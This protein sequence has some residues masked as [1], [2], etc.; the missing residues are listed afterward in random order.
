MLLKIEDYLSFG[1]LFIEKKHSL[2]KK[3]LKRKISASYFYF[4]LFYLISFAQKN[5]NVTIH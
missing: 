5:M 2:V 1:N 3:N 4:I